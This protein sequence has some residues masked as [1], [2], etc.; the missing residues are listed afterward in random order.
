MVS[1]TRT[2]SVV[3]N[4]EKEIVKHWNKI[5]TA[6]TR[7]IRCVGHEIYGNEHVFDTHVTRGEF[8][9]PN[10]NLYVLKNTTLKQHDN[11]V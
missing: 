7:A 11:E 2:R 4:Y 10:S 1:R 5:I 8:V 9:I 6:R 3:T